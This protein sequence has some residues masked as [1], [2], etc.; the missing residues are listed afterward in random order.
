MQRVTDVQIWSLIILAHNSG[1]LPHLSVS[2]YS[3]HVHCCFSN[4][5]TTPS[6][7]NPNRFDV[8]TLISWDNNSCF[9]S[10]VGRSTCIVARL[11]NRLICNNW[12]FDFDLGSKTIV[13]CLQWGHNFGKPD[14]SV[15][16]KIAVFQKPARTGYSSKNTFKMM[17]GE[18]AS[19]STNW[20]RQAVLKVAFPFKEGNHGVYE[21]NLLWLRITL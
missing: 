20:L 21:E 15:S 16:K 18:H 8:A 5:F 2:Y 14:C 6:I 4:D 9:H 17:Y 12:T 10:S 3:I 1:H 13:Y 7:M 19:V 11:A